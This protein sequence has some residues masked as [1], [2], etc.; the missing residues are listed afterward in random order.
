MKN[1]WLDRAKK[2]LEAEATQPGAAFDRLQAQGMI[3]ERGEVTGKL[4]QWDAALA[5]T[6]IKHATGGPQIQ[7]FRCLKPVFGMPGTATIDISRDSIVTYLKEGKK[8]IT[9]HRDERLG[10]W[11]EGCDVH[12]SDSGWIVCGSVNGVEDNVGHL[13]ELQQTDSRL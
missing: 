11:K 2:R 10:L 5:I 6:A 4:H 1:H 13:P 8:I 9:A 3:D 12:L 7:V